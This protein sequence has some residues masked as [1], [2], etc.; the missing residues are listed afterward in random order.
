MGMKYHHF[1]QKHY[2]P[3]ILKFGDGD[4]RQKGGNWAVIEGELLLKGQDERLKNGS[5]KLTAGD[6]KGG[7]EG[8]KDLVNMPRSLFP[9]GRLHSARSRFQTPPPPGLPLARGA[10]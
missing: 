7:G 10:V 4:P 3:E 1:L 2:R 8:D 6:A 9:T 5:S